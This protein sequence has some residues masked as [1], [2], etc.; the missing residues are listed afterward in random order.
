MSTRVFQNR[1]GRSNSAPLPS[2]CSGPGVTL[3][4][5][6]AVPRASSPD[7]RRH[8]LLCGL[9][10][11]PHL[12]ETG[13]S[14][15]HRQ[16]GGERQLGKTT[17]LPE[18]AGGWLSVCLGPHTSWAPE[19]RHPC[20]AL[21]GRGQLCAPDASLCSPARA[22]SQHPPQLARPARLGWARVLRRAHHPAQRRPGQAGPLLVGEA[23]AWLPPGRRGLLLR[24]RQPRAAARLLQGPGLAAGRALPTSVM[25]GG[26]PQV[27]RVSCLA[28]GEAEETERAGRATCSLV[29][30]GGGVGVAGPGPGLLGGEPVSGGARR[31]VSDVA[32]LR[33]CTVPSSNYGAACHPGEG[34][35]YFHPRFI[36]GQVEAQ[37]GQ[38]T[39]LASPSEA[40]L[41]P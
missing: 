32:C 18:E 9:P 4:T 37:G 23:A 30:R 35:P 7:S 33:L 38:T 22:D 39:A 8:V 34:G 10:S 11:V 41:G 1:T 3:V 26:Q 5:C 17:V 14:G 2:L 29:A 36:E 15:S 24:A 16:T 28:R 31:S 13:P 19:R 25:P 40:K 12:E 27:R 21:G 20:P 6:R